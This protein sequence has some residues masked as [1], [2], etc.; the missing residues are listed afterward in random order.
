MSRQTLDTDELPELTP[1]GVR[2]SLEDMLR[3][4]GQQ[5]EMRPIPG[6]P[7]VDYP[8]FSEV[9]DTDFSCSQQEYPGIYT[10]TEAQCQVSSSYHESTDTDI[11]HCPLTT[12]M[13]QLTSIIS[14]IN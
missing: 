9:P 14:C 5:V 13:N 2:L 11:Y 7:G 6:E 1:L 8:V 4:A 10:D 3:S 12:I